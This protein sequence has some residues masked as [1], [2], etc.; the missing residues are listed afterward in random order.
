MES[1]VFSNE[2]RS[3]NDLIKT[4]IKNSSTK[5]VTYIE[6]LAYDEANIFVLPKSEVLFD[7]EAFVTLYSTQLHFHEGWTLSDTTSENIDAIL[8]LHLQP[9]SEQYLYKELSSAEVHREIDWVISST[10]KLLSDDELS[11]KGTRK[12]GRWGVYVNSGRISS[13]STLSD[14]GIDGIISGVA[15]D[16]EWNAIMIMY[17]TKSDYVLFCW[18]AGG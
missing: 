14:L 6:Y 12:S 10:N 7:F 13:G 5:N 16:L 15:L 3:N 17:Q 1:S 9:E 8:N 11:E 2:I 18:G 4:Y